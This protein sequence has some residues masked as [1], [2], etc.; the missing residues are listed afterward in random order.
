M[1]NQ[2][3]YARTMPRRSSS[4]EALA[5]QPLQSAA[6]PCMPKSP[7]DVAAPEL[8]PM[9]VGLYGYLGYDMVRLMEKLPPPC[10][11]TG[12]ACPTQS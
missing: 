12:W 8:P 3:Q 2:P 6:A 10:R 11:P 1:R 7:H 9:A 4:P 5:E